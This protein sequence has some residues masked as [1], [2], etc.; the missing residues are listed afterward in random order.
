MLLRLN[1]PLS[2]TT[3]NEVAMAF[4]EVPMFEVRD[5]AARRVMRRGR[6]DQLSRG[7]LAVVVPLSGAALSGCGGEASCSVIWEQE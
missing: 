7:G 5:N 6:R 4:R 3:T 1:S 2:V